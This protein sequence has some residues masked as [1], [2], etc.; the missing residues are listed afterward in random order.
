[1]NLVFLQRQNLKARLHDIF[2]QGH[3]STSGLLVAYS[4][5]ASLGLPGCSDGY[6]EAHVYFTV[7]SCGSVLHPPRFG[8]QWP[9]VQLLIITNKGN[10][11]YHGMVSNDHD[12]KRHFEI[13]ELNHVQSMF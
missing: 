12:I 1:M 9:T 6:F 13:I 2:G 10:K 5:A 7:Y 4:L 3:E 8:K 11:L